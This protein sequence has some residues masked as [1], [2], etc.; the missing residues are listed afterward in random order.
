MAHMCLW[1]MRA[2]ESR[3]ALH[4][5]N[6]N[7]GRHRLWCGRCEEFFASD[8][9]KAY[10]INHSSN[11]FICPRCFADL[12]SYQALNDHL[13]KKH[14]L[15]FFCE[16]Y[17][18]S[19][20]EALEHAVDLHYYCPDCNKYYSDRGA[21]VRHRASHEQT[22]VQCPRCHHDFRFFSGMVHHL[23]HNICSVDTEE[24]RVYELAVRS[25]VSARCVLP[26]SQGALE[27]Y[28]CESCGRKFMHLSGLC[29]HAENTAGC[30]QLAVGNG[31]LVLL[32]KVLE[33]ALE[34][35]RS[36]F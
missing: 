21:L 25:N 15:C 13:R 31:V 14:H 34:G 11:H 6:E 4:L 22:A 9:D 27:R 30:M 17:S 23:E 36:G 7:T 33:T 8:D 5:H 24:V 1:C 28:Y 2:F 3:E 19:A 18:S 35:T 26:E 32:R 29:Q 16:L 20:E 12:T 10:H